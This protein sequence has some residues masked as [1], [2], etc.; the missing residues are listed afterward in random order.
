MNR[1]KNNKNIPL[2]K[3]C[4]RSNYLVFSRINSF[5]EKKNLRSLTFALTSRDKNSSN[6][7]VSSVGV[8]SKT[9]VQLI[10]GWPVWGT[11]QRV[12][13]SLSS[14]IKLNQLLTSLSVANVSRWASATAP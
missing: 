10:P 1:A 12:G 14:E 11:K 7:E 9:F 4:L 8:T 5:S 13:F 2:R 6:Q 3:D